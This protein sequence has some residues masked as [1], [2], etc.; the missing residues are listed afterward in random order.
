MTFGPSNEFE[1][2]VRSFLQ[3]SQIEGDPALRTI[4]LRELPSPHHKGAHIADAHQQ[5][6][7][8]SSILSFEEGL[9]LARP[10][11]V[12]ASKRFTLLLILTMYLHRRDRTSVCEYLAIATDLDLPAELARDRRALRFTLPSSASD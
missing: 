12:S 9:V 4:A 11:T 10:C 3:T 5:I 8:A 6:V 1:P 7:S 2:Y